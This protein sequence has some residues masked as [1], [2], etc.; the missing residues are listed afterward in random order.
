MLRMLL[1]MLRMRQA[2]W[3]AN[4]TKMCSGMGDGSSAVPNLE[5]VDRVLI[6]KDT[7]AGEYV[8][9]WRWDC[10]VRYALLYTHGGGACLLGW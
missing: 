2:L 6:P 1:R 5:I 8:L 9:G 10:E 4:A 7:P 3:G